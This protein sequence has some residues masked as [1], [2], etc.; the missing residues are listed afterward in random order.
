LTDKGAELNQRVWQLFERAGFVTKPNSSSPAEEVVKLSPVQHRTLD[1]LAEIDNLGVKII[2]W[3]KAKKEL[4]ESLTV[5]IHDY[6]KLR[7]LTSANGVLFVSTEKEVSADNKRYAE[8]KGMRVWGKDELS[9]YETLVDTIGE[10]AKYEMIH[11]L[12]ITTSEEKFTHNTLALRIHQP[13]SNSNQDLFLFTIT[14]DKLLK[15]SVVYRKA[16]RS[17]D[18]YQRMVRK[19]RLAKVKTF[20]TR[21]NA[22]LPPNV[23]LH[24]GDKVYWEEIAVPDKCKDG[25]P[26]Q[27]TK[28][29]D[30]QLV[31][32]RIP[33]EYASLELID[34]QHRLYGFVH[35]EPATKQ[36]FNLVVLGMANLSSQVRRDTFVAINDN[37]RRVD[38]NLVAYLKHTDNESECQKNPELM[39]IKLVVDLNATTPFKNKIKLLDVGDQKIT[40]KGFAGYDLKGLIAE[41]GLL[42]KYY[43][44]NQS[45]EYLSALRLYFNL[46]KSMFKVQWQKPDKY[47]IFT[48]RGISAFLKLLKSMLK[49]NKG[50]LDQ[51]IIQ[52]YLKSLKKKW[53]D[54][55]WE[56]RKLQNAYVGSQGWKSFHRDLVATIKKEYP[57]FRE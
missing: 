33:L 47:I 41:R 20:L 35:A 40:L 7:T 24:F 6:E 5:H 39:A 34:G 10:Y 12:G 37:S 27:L 29:G 14:P 45:A 56:T 31:A 42:R 30:Y 32:L 43:P 46:L 8:E 2:G 4:S 49:T 16:Q 3:N 38:P 26:T 55:K 13:F 22:L 23:I 28:A 54:A 17:S 11:S 57:E 52:K 19:E 53:N 48:N 18:A 44:A 9:Y 25:T 15:T 21:T 51:A 36:S 1:L 50:A